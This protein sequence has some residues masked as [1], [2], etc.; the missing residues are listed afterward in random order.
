M[1]PP[2]LS[3]RGAPVRGGGPSG[4]VRTPASS[5]AGLQSEVGRIGRAISFTVVVAALSLLFSGAAAP[6]LAGIT[7]ASFIL[8]VWLWSLQF[9]PTLSYVDPAILFQFVVVLYTVFPLLTM[10]VYG[11]QFGRAGDNRLYH[12]SLDD[13]IIAEVWI[14]ANLIMAGFG[15]AYL[16][17]RKSRMPSLPDKDRAVS[18]ALWIGF[19]ISFTVLVGVSLVRGTGEYLEEYRFIADLPVLVV[20]ILN[21]NSSLFNAALFGLLAIYFRTNPRIAVALAL[22]AITFFLLTTQ[23]RVSVVLVAAG[24]FISADHFRR[25]F[26]PALLAVCAAL[27]LIAF[28]AAGLF[29]EGLEA[30]S[31][32]AGR[33]EFTAVFIT[34]L[35]I[36]QLYV[37]GSTADMNANLL[38]SDLLRLVP[39]QI[40]WFEKVDPATWYVSTFYPY[41][42]EAGGGL[43]FGMMSESILGGGGP[44]GFVRGLALGAVLSVILNFLTARPSIWRVIIYM[45]LVAALY[46]SFRDT[47]FTLVGRF[48]FQLAPAILVL[49]VLSK[50]LSGRDRGAR[51]FG[52]SRGDSAAEAV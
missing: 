20:Q 30:F 50:I 18:S 39:Q 52:P 14:C 23:A 42:A 33:T 49:F 25:R 26:S 9:R 48:A 28:L 3:M 7:T 35:D 15:G 13:R 8:F 38:F 32:A 17:C 21:I 40:I 51:R 29:R 24:A 16:L 31:D 47:T 44:A 6:V 27:G 1:P 45:W 43:A 10:A 37:I 36:R 2:R 34:A 5:R 12:I 22:V 41:Y 46:H 19:A 4:G 11:Y